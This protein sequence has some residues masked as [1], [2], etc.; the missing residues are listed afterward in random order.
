MEE[1]IKKINNEIKLHYQKIRELNKQK[2]NLFASRY[3][4]NKNKISYKDV[5]QPKLKKTHK[6]II[7]EF[8]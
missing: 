7:L 2:N 3:Y 5:Q 8:N 1:K 6:N 4:K